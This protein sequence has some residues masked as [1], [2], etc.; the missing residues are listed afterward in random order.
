MRW[1]SKYCHWRSGISPSVNVDQAVALG[2]QQW[3]EFEAGWPDYFY[4]II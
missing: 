4:D 2:K 1:S 3:E